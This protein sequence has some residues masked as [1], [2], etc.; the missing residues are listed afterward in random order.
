MQIYLIPPRDR[1]LYGKFYVE[2][3]YGESEFTR[4]QMG[5]LI[6]AGFAA[7]F[8]ISSPV[9]GEVNN[10]VP[11]LT[12][13]GWEALNG[14]SYSAHLNPKPARRPTPDFGRVKR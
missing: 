13:K 2:G 6:E 3:V 11:V 14:S 9:N 4:S 12:I 7:E 1:T 5:W 10:Q 8:D